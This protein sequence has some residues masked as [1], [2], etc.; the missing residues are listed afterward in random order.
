MGRSKTTTCTKYGK[1]T[2]SESGQKKRTTEPRTQTLL[3]AST[4]VMPRDGGEDF[5][6]DELSRCVNG[7]RT[8]L[9]TAKFEER[10][11]NDVITT[12]NYR[13]KL[14][15]RSARSLK[16]TVR[17]TSNREWQLAL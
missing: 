10:H 9:W 6:W 1:C 13:Y 3:V 4:A 7:V 2:L 12:L 16:G 17:Q 8:A 15:H 11:V 5:T 14:L